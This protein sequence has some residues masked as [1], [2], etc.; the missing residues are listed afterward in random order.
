M[1]GETIFPK[2]IPNL[3]QSILKGVRILEF[4]KPKNK[5]NTEIINDHNLRLSLCSK[6]YKD[7]N[8]K[9]IKNTIPKLL[10]EL[11]LTSFI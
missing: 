9:N 10:F 1:N 3:N 8:R 2:T 5:K 4:I 7:I 11:I 6:G